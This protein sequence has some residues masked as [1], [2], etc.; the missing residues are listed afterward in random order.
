MTTETLPLLVDAADI[1]VG[2]E[3]MFLGQ[4][5]RVQRIG[6][7]QPRGFLGRWRMAHGFEG[8]KIVLIDGQT[9]EVVRP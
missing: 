2:D 4:P 6:P 9:L 7:R 1:R 8:W 3:V 5:H